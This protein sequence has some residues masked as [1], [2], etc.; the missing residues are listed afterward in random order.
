[1]IFTYAPPEQAIVGRGVQL[2]RL[3]RAR[4]DAGGRQH[5]AG[6]GKPGVW[7]FLL[8]LGTSMLADLDSG[9]YRI[10]MSEGDLLPKCTVRSR[11]R[12]S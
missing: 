8:R 10:I 9:A 4:E 11:F 2:S 12:F 6:P 3:A 5:A 7:S 1:M